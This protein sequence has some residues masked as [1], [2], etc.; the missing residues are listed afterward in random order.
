M[1]RGWES[2]DAILIMLE[3]WGGSITRGIGDNTGEA[4]AKIETVPGVSPSQGMGT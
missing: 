2:V 3:T 1:I 4:R